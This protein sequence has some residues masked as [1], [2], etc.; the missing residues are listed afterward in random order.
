MSQA[1]IKYRN[2]VVVI[3]S[4]YRQWSSCN[5]KREMIACDELL[6]EF[7]LVCWVFRVVN[8]APCRFC[9]EP[10]VVVWTISLVYL[11]IIR[12]ERRTFCLLIFQTTH[13]C[14]PHKFC[15]SLF[16]LRLYIAVARVPRKA[17]IEFCLA[18]MVFLCQNA[19]KWAS[20]IFKSIG[21]HLWS[22]FEESIYMTSET[23]SLTMP[24]L[25]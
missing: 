6:L 9:S 14:I 4:W 11:F 17:K 12:E 2:G 13:V 5:E 16:I 3:S 22:D 25:K 20:A 10:L 24:K 15:S 7:V 19:L 23:I 21:N 1:I 8:F 18:K